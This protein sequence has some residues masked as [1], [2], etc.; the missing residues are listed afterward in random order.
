MSD[1]LKSYDCLMFNSLTLIWELFQC[2][3]SA[4]ENTI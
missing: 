4:K 2:I 1:G 3:A